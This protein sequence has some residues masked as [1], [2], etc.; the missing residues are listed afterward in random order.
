MREFLNESRFPF[1]FSVKKASTLKLLGWHFYESRLSHFYEF[2][3]GIHGVH[4]AH[5][6][7][8]RTTK[9]WDVSTEPLLLPFAHLLASLTDTGFC[10]TI[11]MPMQYCQ[12]LHNYNT[13]QYNAI[14]LNIAYNIPQYRL[15][16]I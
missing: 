9:N 1:N 3:F 10:S 2:R 5:S 15:K 14:C 8:S 13:I 11:P 16:R 7:W 4:G 12:I 6:Q